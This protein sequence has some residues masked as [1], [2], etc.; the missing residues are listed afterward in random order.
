MDVSLKTYQAHE[1][2]VELYINLLPGT[3]PITKR[4]CRMALT[5]LAELKV[6]ISGR[7]RLVHLF[8]PASAC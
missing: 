6:Q 1:R 5:K 8:E 4:P 3:T 7:V 2:E